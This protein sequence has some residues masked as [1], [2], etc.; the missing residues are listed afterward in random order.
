MSSVPGPSQ[1]AARKAQCLAS[2]RDH[3]NSVDE[4]ETHA[5][6]KLVRLGIGRTV[7]DFLFVEDHDIRREPNLQD[8]PVREVQARGRQCG[9]LAD[10]R[11]ER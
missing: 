7:S 11:L 1:N 8:A 6:G 2:V 9:E 5:D 3:R 4:H 10:C